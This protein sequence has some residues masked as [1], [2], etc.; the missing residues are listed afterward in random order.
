MQRGAR[1]IPFALSA[2]SIVLH[3][4]TGGRYGIFRDEMYYWD[5]ANHLAWGYVDHPPFSIALLAGWKALFGSSLFSLRVLPALAG[6]ALMLLVARLAGRLGGG[7]LAQ[8]L[9]AL[10]TLAVPSYLGITG[11]YSMNSYELLFWAWGFLIVL[12]IQERGRR[13]AWGALGVC[14]GLGML[15]KISV[16]VFAASAAVV[17]LVSTRLR[18]LRT[19]GP[20]LATAIAVVL[21]APYVAWQV[22]NDWPTREFIANAQ[23]YKMTAMN[24]AAF[25]GNVAMEMGPLLAPLHLV[26]LAVLLFYRPLKS[27]RALAWVFLLSLAVFMLNRS[28]PYYTVAAFPPLVAAAAV[29]V[30]SV[31]RR[32]RRAWMAPLVA[33]YAVVSFAFT[34]PLAI[35]L[36]PVARLIAYQDAIGIRPSSGENRDTGELPQFFADR[37]GWKELAAQVTEVFDALPPEDRAA[38]LIVGE[39][40]GQAGAINY[41]GRRRLTRAVSQHNSYY[42]WGPGTIEPRVYIII[43][44]D[45][46]GLEATFAEV[47][48][49]ARTGARYAMPDETGVPIWVCRGI[50][51]PLDE[52]WRRGRMFI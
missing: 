41:F 30:E 46:E 51:L 10:F 16:G 37:F 6:G 12:D 21:F 52:A 13:A 15:N 8:V 31:S 38:C 49:V 35:P 45:R 1:A 7:A 26:G 48:E 34:A 20:Y 39:N 42:L 9:A 24:P 19:P 36:L 11:I 43:G 29:W 4:A 22:A 3:L 14:I 23:R 2:A 47:R 50:R 27:Y 44:Q 33:V 28:K 25:L 17:I 5:C 18:T 32:P 40:Y